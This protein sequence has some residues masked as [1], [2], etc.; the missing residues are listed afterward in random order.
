ME[1]GE[2][3]SKYFVCTC[4]LIY[5]LLWFMQIIKEKKKKLKSHRCFL[6]D[7]KYIWKNLLVLLHSEIPQ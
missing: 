5:I 7:I 3:T 6:E 4:V 2:I 1:G